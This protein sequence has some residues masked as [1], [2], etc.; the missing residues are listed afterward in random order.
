MRTWASLPFN[1]SVPYPTRA[2]LTW[3]F[4]VVGATPAMEECEQLRA[5][6]FPK[7]KATKEYIPERV[8][9]RDGASSFMI[10]IHERQ[11]TPPT[12]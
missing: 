7:K 2:P 5:V 1:S 10:E 8:L 4:E 9:P 3:F 12:R 6:A 11:V